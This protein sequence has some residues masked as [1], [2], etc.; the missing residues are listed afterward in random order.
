MPDYPMLRPEQVNPFNAALKQA[1]QTYGHGLQAAYAKPN[2]EQALQKAILANKWNP[3]IWESEIGLRGAQAGLAGTESDKLRFLMG[4]PQY[5]NPEARLISQALG[6]NR[7]EGQQIN[8]QNSNPGNARGRFPNL[9]AQGQQDFMPNEEF[10][11]ANRATPEEMDYIAEHGNG[12]FQKNSGAANNPTMNIGGQ[13]AEFVPEEGTGY[14]PEM[15]AEYQNNLKKSNVN[16]NNYNPNALAFNPPQLNSPTG[17]PQL[18]NL[19]YKKFGMS[20]LDQAQLE[21]SQ[22]QAENI[23]L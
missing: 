19:W 2:M 23:K 13:E 22:K 18:D 7:G 1:F 11:A 5:I 6:E 4:N 14:T 10:G 16:G 8:P 20:P 12:E 9:A 3:K 17:H 15:A 21:L